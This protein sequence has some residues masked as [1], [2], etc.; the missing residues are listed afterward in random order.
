MT[1]RTERDEI[2]DFP[3]ADDLVTAGRVAPPAAHTSATVQKRL[4][5]LQERESAP[6]VD[7]TPSLE[8]EPLVVMRR[9]APTLPVPPSRRRLLA[10]AAA[11][12]TVVAG[13]GVFQ[14]LEGDS[15]PETDIS[16]ASFLGEMAEVSAEQS[17]KASGKYWRVVAESVKGR[18]AFT[19]WSYTD[20]RGRKWMLEK[21]KAHRVK[22]DIWVVGKLRFSWNELPKLPTNPKEL[23]TRFSKTRWDRFYEVTAILETYPASPQLRSA[24]FTVLAQTPGVKLKGDIKDSRSRHGTALTITNGPGKRPAQYCV[25]EP[26]TGRIL[27]RQHTPYTKP[28]GRTTY[29]KADWTNRID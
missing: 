13:A 24:L 26:K 23:S 28:I 14:A 11:V 16:A 1:E 5:L 15:R 21:G 8:E 29:L 20:Q 4:G 19:T 25:I 6:S 18:K 3:G 2:L 12:A 9:R 7:R 17:P 22:G 10:A 27:E